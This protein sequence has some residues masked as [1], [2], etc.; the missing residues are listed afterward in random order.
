MVQKF[1]RPVGYEL[2][3]FADCPHIQRG[4]RVSLGLDHLSRFFVYGYDKTA[5]TVTPTTAIVTN[6]V[7]FYKFFAQ[8]T[9]KIQYLTC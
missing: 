3:G 8:F 4:I 7:L 9:V 5:M 1:G 6:N 2:P